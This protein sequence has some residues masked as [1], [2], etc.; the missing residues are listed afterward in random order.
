MKNDNNNDYEDN[1]DVVKIAMQ[2]MSQ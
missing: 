1:D 2:L